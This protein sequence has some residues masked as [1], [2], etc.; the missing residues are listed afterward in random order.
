[1]GG[2]GG[3][4]GKDSSDP[5][6]RV[7]ANSCSCLVNDDIVIWLEFAIDLDTSAVRVDGARECVTVAPEGAEEDYNSSSEWIGHLVSPTKL[8]NPPGT[9]FGGGYSRRASLR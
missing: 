7:D 4:E 5:I 1:M 9:G 6:S 2:P 8:L 3:L